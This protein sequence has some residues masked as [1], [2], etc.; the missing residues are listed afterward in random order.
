MGL[1]VW[2]AEC[3]TPAAV[4]MMPLSLIPVRLAA[5]CGDFI[6]SLGLALGLPWGGV[7]SWWWQGR[8][9]PLCVEVVNGLGEMMA[10]VVTA[11][12]MTALQRHV[13]R[14]AL[15]RDARLPRA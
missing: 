1:A 14:L 13:V 12:L 2:A 11:V 5:W 15:E 9:W 3:L 6:W 7:L 8:P 4:Y 10:M